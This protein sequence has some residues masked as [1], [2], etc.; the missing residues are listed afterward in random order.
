MTF[1]EAIEK[2][3]SIRKTYEVLERKK[4]GKE[5]ERKD[6][7]LGFVHDVGDF[8]K[9]TMIMDGT[10]EANPDSKYM[11]SHE[12]SDCLWS[13]II[14]ADKYDIDL[15]ESFEENMNSMEQRLIEEKSGE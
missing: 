5:W 9:T 15:K 8:V 11:L 4:F 3:R 14:L 7:V 6:L 1:E 12:L 2:A 13:I 10:R